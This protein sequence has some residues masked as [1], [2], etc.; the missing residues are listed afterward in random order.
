M[1]ICMFVMKSL[2]EKEFLVQ[3]LADRNCSEKQ[4]FLNICD[5]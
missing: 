5:S 4:I 1:I 2:V 3:K